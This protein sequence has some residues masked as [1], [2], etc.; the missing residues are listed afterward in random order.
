[1]SFH[2]DFSG[3]ERA[4]MDPIQR[5]KNTRR[6]RIMSKE[7]TVSEAEL[8]IAI[9]NECL[10]RMKATAE[11]LVNHRRKELWDSKVRLNMLKKIV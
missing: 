4:K 2:T 1:M 6:A 5:R 9:S 10:E 8:R 11:E 3:S 7:L